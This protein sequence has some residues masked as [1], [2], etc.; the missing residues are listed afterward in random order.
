MQVVLAC[1]TF[2][3]DDDPRIRSWRQE[4]NIEPIVIG[5]LRDEDAKKIVERHGGGWENFSS[6]QKEILK[7]PQSLYLWTCLPAD[8]QSRN[9]RNATD[10]MRLYWDDLRKKI[11]MTR[12][13]L[14][15][16]AHFLDSVITYMDKKG[17]LTAPASLANSGPDVRDVLISLN[18][19]AIDDNKIM[20]RHQSYLDYLIAERTLRGIHQEDQTV[21]DWIKSHDQSLFRRD[22]LRQILTLLW[23]DD[24]ETFISAVRSILSDSKFGFTSGIWFL[25]F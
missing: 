6:K 9:F 8:T 17:I 22:Q 2:D 16:C 10:L 13:S 11:S 15:E 4:K 7:S 14:D 24:F 20:F 21:L 12:C 23:D 5:Q 25:A 19:W 18:V 1:R 3:W